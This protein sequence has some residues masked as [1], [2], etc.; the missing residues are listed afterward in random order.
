MFCFIAL[1]ILVLSVIE[2]LV[3]NTMINEYKFM[4]VAFLSISAGSSSLRK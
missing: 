3:M 2:R 1:V 4:V